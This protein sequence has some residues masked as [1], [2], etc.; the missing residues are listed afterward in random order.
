MKINIKSIST[1]CYSKTLLIA[2]ILTFTIFPLLWILSE[3]HTQW[4]LIATLLWILGSIVVFHPF[5][6]YVYPHMLTKAGVFLLTSILTIVSIWF[7]VTIITFLLPDNY[8]YHAILNTT[9]TRISL[10]GYFYIIIT[11]TIL[12]NMDLTYGR[13]SYKEDKLF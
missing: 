7:N 5:M 8:L 1:V 10:F 6:E 11:T 9:L 3:N 13:N 12:S 2:T 4:L